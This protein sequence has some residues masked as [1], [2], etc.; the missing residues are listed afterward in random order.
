MHVTRY[1]VSLRNITVLFKTILSF[2]LTIFPHLY[3]WSG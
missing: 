3:P 2:L 1:S